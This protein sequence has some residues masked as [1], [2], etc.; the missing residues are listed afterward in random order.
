MGKVKAPQNYEE[1]ENLVRLQIQ[2]NIHLEYKS[3]KAISGKQGEITKDVSAFANSDGGVLIYGITEDKKRHIPESIDEGIDHSKYSK[4]WLEQIIQS[5]VNPV[6]DDLRINPIPIPPSKT[7]SLYLVDIKKSLRAPHQ[8]QDKR[9]YKRYNFQSVPMEDY[10]INDIRN[11][12]VRY[13]PLVNVALILKR[14]P[15][16]ELVIENIGNFPAL[17]LQ[18]AFTP[19]IPWQFKYPPQL[20]DGIKSLPS[21][22][23]LSFCIGSAIPAMA[24]NNEK[25]KI[26]TVTVSYNHPLVDQR[27]SDSFILDMTNFYHASIPVTELEQFGERIEK[28]FDKLSNSVEKAIK[29]LE[30]VSRLTS[31]TGLRISVPTLRNINQLLSGKWEPTGFDPFETSIREFQEILQISSEEAISLKHHLRLMEKLGCP[32]DMEGVSRETIEKLKLIFRFKPDE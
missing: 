9:Y 15:T 1:V 6:I 16:L 11:R 14:G 8:A 13:P 20:K 12:I 31:A 29:E 17:N 28:S 26:F 23:R 10:E 25:P 18:F 3:S 32:Q 5:N 24:Y 22:Q 19:E 7:T 4:E 27:I 30:R 21:G 2:E